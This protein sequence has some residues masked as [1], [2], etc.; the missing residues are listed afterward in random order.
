MLK[1]QDNKRYHQLGVPGFSR[2]VKS[3]QIL[4]SVLFVGLAVV[5]VDVVAR[6]GLVIA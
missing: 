5:V 3:S 4:V 2:L 1:G 6:F